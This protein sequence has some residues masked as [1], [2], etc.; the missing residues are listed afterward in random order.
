MNNYLYK[1]ESLLR[2]LLERK[3]IYSINQ[4]LELLKNKTNT[5]ALAL[6]KISFSDLKGW[7]FNDEFGDIRHKTGKFFQIQGFEIKII[8]N[9]REIKWS[10]PIINQPEIGFLGCLTKEI[11]GILYFLIQAK[12][13]PGNIN[14]AQY[15]PTLQATRSNFTQEHRGAKPPYLSEFMNIED[16]LV[17]SDQLQSEHGTRFLKKRNRNLIIFNKEIRYDPESFIWLTLAQIKELCKLDNIINM[18]LKSVIGSLN[19]SF[20]PDLLRRIYKEYSLKENSFGYKMLNSLSNKNFNIEK[21]IFI[22]SWLSNHKFNNNIELKKLPI[23]ELQ[24][25]EF[26]DKEI[27]HYSDKFFSVNWI[28]VNIKG[29]EVLKWDQPIFEVKDIGIICF[30]TRFIN[31]SYYFL[32]QAKKEFGLIDSIELGPT[33]MATPSNYN[34]PEKEIPFYKYFCSIPKKDYK[35]NAISSEEGGRFLRDQNEHIIIECKENFKEDIPNN[36]LWISYIQLM[37]LM[38]N[39]NT[40][41]VQARTLLSSIN[42]CEG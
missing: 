18:D 9:N 10:Q 24:D 33:I 36:F 37:E 16:S 28:S 5:S 19:L 30:F 12:V 7:Y 42:Y 38:L 32:V 13:E 4:A 21:K 3:G 17:L 39:T 29:R 2:S 31:G 25:W 34:N 22:E 23:N 27:S 15:S 8:E 35:F 1:K 11:N 40:V 41:N 26:E 6:E 20:D 14:S